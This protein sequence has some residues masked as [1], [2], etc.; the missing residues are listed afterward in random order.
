MLFAHEGRGKCKFLKKAKTPVAAG[1][2]EG[3]L[4]MFSVSISIEMGKIA[5]AIKL[6][7]QLFE[8]APTDH[9]HRGYIN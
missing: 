6:L 9:M 3:F 2:N 7:L 4:N 5:I 1:G 8:N